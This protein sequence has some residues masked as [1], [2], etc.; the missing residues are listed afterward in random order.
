MEKIEYDDSFI[1]VDDSKEPVEE[2]DIITPLNDPNED[3]NKTAENKFD[4]TTKIKTVDPEKLLEDT[5]LD[6]F[7]GE[8]SE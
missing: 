1:W 5:N 4:E 6:L 8:D 3:I 7:G 2:R